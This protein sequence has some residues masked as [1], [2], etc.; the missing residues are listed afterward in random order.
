MEVR[1]EYRDKGMQE[2]Y[3][4]PFEERVVQWPWIMDKRIRRRYITKEEEE[5]YMAELMCLKCGK[6]CGGTCGG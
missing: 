5:A 1:G 2:V 3:E 6:P 4:M